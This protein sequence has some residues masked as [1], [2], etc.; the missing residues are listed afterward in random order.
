M[1][2]LWLLIA[3]VLLSLSHGAVAQAPKEPGSDIYKR[4]LDNDK[5]R[6]YQ[7]NFK[8]GAKLP[9]RSFPNHL[10]YMLTDGTLAFE[11]VGRTGYEMTF[12]AGEVQWF[13]AQTRAMENVSDQEVRLLVVEFK[14]SAVAARSTKAKGKRK[15]RK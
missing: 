9:A 15:R 5:V 10:V 13:P 14:D 12:K 6:V 2:R 3:A 11:Q 1:T 7:A 8:P 4:L